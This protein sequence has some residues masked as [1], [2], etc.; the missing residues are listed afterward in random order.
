MSTDKCCKKDRAD[1]SH[2]SVDKVFCNW[3]VQIKSPFE[4]MEKKGTYKSS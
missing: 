2:V 4:G 1:I 3:Q